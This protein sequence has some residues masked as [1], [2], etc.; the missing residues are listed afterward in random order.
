MDS[1]GGW[2]EVEHNGLLFESEG[3]VRLAY[4]SVDIAVDGLF[5]IDLVGIDLVYVLGYLRESL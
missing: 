2:I 3:S 1:K 4:H 5:K